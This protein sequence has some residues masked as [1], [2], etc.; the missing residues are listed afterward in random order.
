MDESGPFGFSNGV[1]SVTDAGPGWG[2]RAG[3]DFFPWLAI[4]GRYVGM[5]N[6]AKDSVSPGGSTGY[7]TT[8]GEAVVRLTAP[9]PFVHPYIF[10]G[11][12]YYWNSY[13][14]SSGAKAQSV[15]GSSAQPGLPLGFGIEIP[16]SWHIS[17]GA[18]A[19]Y[20]FNLGESFSSDTTNG[21][22]GGDLSTFD[23]VVRFRP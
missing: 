16:L 20:H 23:A 13:V 12:A 3:V 10:G 17:L 11:V 7:L 9:L 6:A 1:G 15:L 8:G 14:G 5:Y 4:E 19:A 22:D 2:V 18:E 21:I